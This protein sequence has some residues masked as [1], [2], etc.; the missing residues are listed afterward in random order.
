MNVGNKVRIIGNTVMHE[1][2]QLFD[3]TPEYFAE[4]ER[5][6]KGKIGEIINTMEVDAWKLDDG[7]TPW[8]PVKLYMVHIEELSHT[9]YSL[10]FFAE[11]DLDLAEQM[12]DQANTPDTLATIR[13]FIGEL[14]DLSQET[15]HQAIKS[16]R[17]L[18]QHVL[19]S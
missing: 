16:G 11:C 10:T 4:V 1:G 8:P 17:K 7:I 3:E 2:K 19:S 14:Q 6:T 13:Y 18:R 9:D 15:E 12:V 5:Q